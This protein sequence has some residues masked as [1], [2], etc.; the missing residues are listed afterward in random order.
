MPLSSGSA[1]CF[2]SITTHLNIEKYIRLISFLLPFMYAELV[3]SDPI[4]FTLV[5]VVRASNQ[6]GLD[7]HEPKCSTAT[8]MIEIGN[9][10]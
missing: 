3:A 1:I 2:I 7:F 5:G 9:Y 6:G 8:A 4:Y 10:I